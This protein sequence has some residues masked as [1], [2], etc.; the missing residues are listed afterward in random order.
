MAPDS[1]SSALSAIAALPP[2]RLRDLI[3]K[4]LQSLDVR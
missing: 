3:Q 4:D 1:I 2:T